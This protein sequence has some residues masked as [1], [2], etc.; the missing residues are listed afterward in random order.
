MMLL[1][2]LIPGHDLP[3][4]GIPTTL[5]HTTLDRTPLDERSAGRGDLYPTT[6]N[7]HNRQTSMLR[8]GFEPAIPARQ[9]PQTQASDSAATATGLIIFLNIW[10]LSPIGHFSGDRGSTVVNVLCYKSEGHWF[11]PSWCHWSFHWHNILP[12]ALW[13]WGRLSL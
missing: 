10:F 4:R 2:F 9:R 7:N 3:L 11:D 6:H 13:P 1:F 8:A 5:G 12:I